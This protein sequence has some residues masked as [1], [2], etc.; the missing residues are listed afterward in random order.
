MIEEKC[1]TLPRGFRAADGSIHTEGAMRLAVAGD[2]ILPLEDPRVQ[3][4]RAYLV[5]LL[6]ARVI[7]RLGPLEGDAITPTVIEG[8]YTRDLAHLQSFYRELNG[9]DTEAREVVCPHCAR[10]FSLE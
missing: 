5:I 4:N 8:L 1:F 9:L 2:E 10:S 3:G 6:L 7:T